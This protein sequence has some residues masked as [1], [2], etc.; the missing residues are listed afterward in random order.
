M[1]QLVIRDKLVDKTG[2]NYILYDNKTDTMYKMKRSDV[3]AGRKSE[4]YK[5]DFDK[6]PISN[7]PAKHDD[8]HIAVEAWIKWQD[9]WKPE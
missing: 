1:Y 7:R 6:N 8:A 5:F 9:I 3:N 4:K 2:K